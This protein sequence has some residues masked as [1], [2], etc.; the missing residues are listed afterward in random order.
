MRTDSFLGTF[1][2]PI[3]SILDRSEYG[4]GNATIYSNC[5]GKLYRFEVLLHIDVSN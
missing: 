3:F 5:F 4:N 1:A 2:D